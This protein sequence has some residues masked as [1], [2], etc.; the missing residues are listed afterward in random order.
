VRT[1]QFDTPLTFGALRI[2]QTD[3][4][5]QDW[6]ST[7]SIPEEAS[8]SD[9]IIVSALSKNDKRLRFIIVGADALSNC[10]SITFDKRQ[11]QIRL[12]CVPAGGK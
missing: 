2:D 1:L 8:D 12:S 4:R 10:S 6:G 5:T 9:E 3:V 7:S 11:R